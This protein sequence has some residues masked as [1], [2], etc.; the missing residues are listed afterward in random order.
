ML[1]LLAGRES[2]V[3]LAAVNGPASTVISG[4]AAAVDEIAAVLAERGRKT[5]RLRVSH[6]FHSPLM[7]PMLSEFREVV[8]Q[9]VPGEATIPVISDLTGEP[10]TSGQ[11]GSPDYWVEHVRGTVRFQDGVRHLERDGVT[12]FLELGPD[13][14]L[15]ALGQDCLTGTTG[16]ATAVGDSEGTGTAALTGTPLLL[17]LLRKDRPEAPAAAT[18]LARLHVAGV[19]VDWSAVHSGGPSR[20]AVDLPTYA[21]QRGSY[22]LAAGPAT[23]DLP[24]AGLRTVDHPLLGAGTELADSDGFLF[25]G[26]FSVRS[27]PWLADHGVYEGVLFPATAFLEL[28]VRAG[29]QVGCDR[30]EELTLEAPLVLPQGGAVALQLTVGSPDASG[31]RPLS[32]HA[33]PAD[34]GP[35]APWTRHASGLLPPA[36]NPGPADPF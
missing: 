30:V 36:R 9:V 6:A 1:P 34:D 35:D 32:V 23:A 15:T 14:A 24:A 2:A 18:A 16:T 22:W 29:D 5:R 13:G 33:R 12:A 25:T 27:H 3:G 11:L 20:P 7:E 19:P 4:D 8:A 17:P 21:F 31:T 10:A 26:R 28:A